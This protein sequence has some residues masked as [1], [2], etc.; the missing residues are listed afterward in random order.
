MNRIEKKYTTADRLIIPSMGLAGLINFVPSHLVELT[1]G[2]VYRHVQL[3]VAFQDPISKKYYEVSFFRVE[4]H[5]V[6]D[7]L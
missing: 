4:L 1:V 6:E 5:G 3:I 7:M 2:S